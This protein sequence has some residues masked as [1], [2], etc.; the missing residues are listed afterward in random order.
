ML[1]LRAGPRATRAALTEALT[2]RWAV[3]GPQ[4]S[5]PQVP[6]AV[7]L[8]ELSVGLI[9][10]APG[11]I[12]VDDHLIAL[13]LRGESGALAVLT[14]RR[15][16]PLADLR[17]A[18]REN[19]LVTLHSWLRHWGSRADVSAELFVHPQTVSYRLKR[20][21]ELYGTDLDDPSARFEILVVLAS[22]L[23]G[24]P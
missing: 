13:A 8:A 18:Q 17:P 6:T 22:R 7:R 20:L 15:L 1:L 10:P 23:G 4:L 9:G 14:A 11:P 19:L 24:Q 12:F 16:A 3:V 21:R 5:W 2:G